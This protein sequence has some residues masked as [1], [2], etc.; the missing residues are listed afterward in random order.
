MLFMTAYVRTRQQ[1]VLDDKVRLVSVFAIE[2]DKH[3]GRESK[4]W[5]ESKPRRYILP[6][7]R[8]EKAI[9]NYRGSR[10]G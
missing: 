4:P 3:P 6:T 5:D 2:G 10:T 8:T 9:N 7:D 1:N